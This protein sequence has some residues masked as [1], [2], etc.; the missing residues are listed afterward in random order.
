MNLTNA[1]SIRVLS[2]TI[3]LCLARTVKAGPSLQLGSVSAAPGTPAVVM[4]SLNSEVVGICGLLLDIGYEASSPVNAPPLFLGVNETSLATPFKGSLY[5][6]STP[7]DPSTGLPLAQRKRIG[8][9]HGEPV[10]GPAAILKLTFQVPS[11]AAEGTVYPITASASAYDAFGISIPVASAASTITVSR[12]GSAILFG[13][14]DGDGRVT[15]SD[16][17]LILRATLGLTMLDE[18]QRSRADLNHNGK[19][20]VGDAVAALR[21]A[22]GLA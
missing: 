11:S 13:D 5:G 18:A 3:L 9:V 16:A 12:S 21:L 22:V 4:V 14:V 1:I 8:I 19:P 7:T 2:F 17:L 20:E 15:V 6:S 10:D